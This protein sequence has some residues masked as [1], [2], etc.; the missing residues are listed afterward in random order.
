MS[1]VKEIDEM[2]M[3]YAF[4]A[5]GGILYVLCT[6]LFALAPSAYASIFGSA[7]HV[8]DVSVK[9]FEF[10]IATTGFIVTIIAAFISGYVL[11]WALN[12]FKAAK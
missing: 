7:F 11:A 10:G 9:T 6:A 8:V 1:G 3:G 2:R 5:A 4:G 12:Y